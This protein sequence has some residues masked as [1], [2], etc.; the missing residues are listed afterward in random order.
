MKK[1]KILSD[2]YRVA[3]V[4]SLELSSELPLPRAHGSKE[5][6][7]SSPPELFVGRFGYPKVQVGP[8]IPPIHGDTRHLAT[9]EEWFGRGLREIIGMRLQLVRGKREVR[10]DRVEDRYSSELREALLSESSVE[11]EARFKNTPRGYSLS[12]D[13]QPFGP[14]APLEEL[15]LEPGRSDP[16]LERLYYDR[17]ASAAEAMIELYGSGLHV[18]RIQQALSA[19]LLGRRRKFVPTRWAITA[20]DDLISKHLIEEVKGYGELGEY[21]VYRG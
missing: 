1:L 15:R 4:V 16:R 9:P 8:L 17:D 12:E 10:V 14:S 18:S 20:V 2:D 19:G 6:A 11:A 7:G 5:L 21:R 3:D 13:L